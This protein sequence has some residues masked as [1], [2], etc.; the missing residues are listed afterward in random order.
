[1]EK[2]EGDELVD[3]LLAHYN[4]SSDSD[5]AAKLGTAKQNIYSMRKR[6]RRDVAYDII[7]RL[8]GGEADG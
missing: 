4:A 6:T 3:R 7:M 2:R 1:M 5:L 8:I